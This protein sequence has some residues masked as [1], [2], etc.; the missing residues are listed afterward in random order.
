MADEVSN[1]PDMPAATTVN[2]QAIEQAERVKET[3]NEYFKS[4]CTNT[5]IIAIHFMIILSVCPYLY[6]SVKMHLFYIISVFKNRCRLQT[7][8]SK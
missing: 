8:S 4:K 6:I 3:A 5:I 2:E 1:G 7:R